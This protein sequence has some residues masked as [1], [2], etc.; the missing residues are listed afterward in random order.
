M[1]STRGHRRFKVAFR[2]L[3]PLRRIADVYSVPR[4]VTALIEPR[5]TIVTVCRNV[6]DQLAIT[7]NSVLDAGCDDLEY[8][9]VDG[10]STDSTV[11]YLRTLDHPSVRFVSEADEGIADAMN[12]GLR[13]AR[14][15]WIMH[16]HAGDR[17][18][19]G[20]LAEA[21][22]RAHESSADVF[23]S[24][25][26]KEEQFGVATYEANPDRLECESSVP[27]PG[28]IARTDVWRSLGGFN[29]RY[30]NA[31]DY[32]LFL[33]A[34]LAGKEFSVSASPLAV[35]AWGGQSEQSLWTTL[36]ETHKIRRSLLSAGFA[37][38]TPFLVMLFVKATV[39]SQMQRIG[40]N[41]IVNFYRRH[42]ASQK[43]VPVF[44]DKPNVVHNVTDEV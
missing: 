21:M 31:M 23:C 14:G 43:K 29:G 5:L 18:V 39:R 1:A 41:G 16:L 36:S 3:N 2:D 42:F 7:V 12:K 44:A 25:I 26:V 6:K 27:H 38:T 32:D 34:R 4:S 8:L 19:P 24:A 40:L 17:L 9:I 20:A 13:L 37:R 28:V 35:M 15:V 30:R 33:R 11:T 22:V 10:A